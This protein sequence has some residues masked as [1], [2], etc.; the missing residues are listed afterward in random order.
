MYTPGNEPEELR[1]YLNLLLKELHAQYPDDLIVMDMWNHERWDKV[2]GY[3]TKKLGYPNGRAFL[4]AYGFEIAESLDEEPETE[5]EPIRRTTSRPS[6]E[7][8]STSVEDRTTKSRISQIDYDPTTEYKPQKGMVFCKKCGARISKKAKVCPYCG[9]R[10]KKSF[11]GRVFLGIFAAILILI[12]LGVVLGQ[13]N[14]P[15]NSTDST[16]VSSG[17]S[18]SSGENIIQAFNNVTSKSKLEEITPP[19]IGTGDFGNKTINGS[20]K[21][22]SGKTL[23]YVQLTFALYD[24]DGAQIGTAVANINNLTADAVWKYSAAPLTMDDWTSFQL[25]ETTSW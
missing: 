19:E 11:V 1:K 10:L 7:K 23:S 5:P 21:N 15:N 2:A 20:L 17:S 18:S 8:Y 22:I 12:I 25:T 3:L 4:H 6:K 13:S 14:S 24:S 9:T 16:I